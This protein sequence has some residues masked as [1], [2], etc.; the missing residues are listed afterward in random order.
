MT[1]A[2]RVSPAFMI[3]H[4]PYSDQFMFQRRFALGKILNVGCNTDGANLGK[5][6]DAVNIDLFRKDAFT[7]LD[8]PAHVLADARKLPFANGCF[9]TVV[10]GEI[11]EH[12]QP[13]DA[14]RA[15]REAM[16]MLRS[17]GPRPGPIDAGRV[18]VTMP[19]DPR[20]GHEAQGFNGDHFRQEYIPGIAAYHYRYIGPEELFAWVEACGF[21]VWLQ[22]TIN[23]P[24]GGVHGTGLVLYPEA[25]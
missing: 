17:H 14:K 22:G 3:D 25:K 24:W 8:I 21:A 16:R 15:L 10:L 1:T 18:I 7:G 23:Y 20:E 4:T 19:H 5:R 2:T 13:E 6:P 12:F 9:D 11:L